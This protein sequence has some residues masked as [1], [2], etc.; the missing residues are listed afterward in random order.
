MRT[1]KMKRINL[2]ILTRIKYVKNELNELQIEYNKLEERIVESE[3]ENVEEIEKIKKE[4]EDV[5]EELLDKVDTINSNL[6]LMTKKYNKKDYDILE[7]TCK[8]DIDSLKTLLK[9]YD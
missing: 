9:V 7:Q 3:E 6:G 5:K 1:S 4:H 8:K 2:L